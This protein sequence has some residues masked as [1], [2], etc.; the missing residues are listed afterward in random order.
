MT[1][2]YI[3]FTRP[4]VKAIKMTKRPY[5]FKSFLGSWS[6]KDLQENKT[7]VS[8]LYSFSLRF[9]FNLVINL[10]KKN[11]QENVKQRLK[12]MK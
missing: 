6:F 7:E 3:I 2:E 10:I 1:T 5:L 4:K 11:L 12:D 8:F 9:P